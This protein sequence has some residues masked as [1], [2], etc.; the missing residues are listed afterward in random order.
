M[1]VDTLYQKLHRNFDAQ[2]L[3]LLWATYMPS[4]IAAISQSVDEV[5]RVITLVI[6]N[7]NIDRRSLHRIMGDFIFFIEGDI[8]A[9]CQQ[10][11]NIAEY[12]LYEQGDY[13]R[14]ISFYEHVQNVITASGR[15]DAIPEVTHLLNYIGTKFIDVMGCIDV[16]MR[17]VRAGRF[18]PDIATRILEKMQVFLVQSIL[19]PIRRVHDIT[20]END[21]V[22]A[23][24][25]PNDEEIPMLKY[26]DEVLE[27]IWLGQ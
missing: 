6:Q 20:S 7:P 10:L 14:I 9:K 25:W 23:V 5:G 26:S 18:T 22:E 4:V 12:S 19:G 13:M 8:I 16:V 17:G 21:F 24:L 27:K 2:Y 11:F 1:D 15:E 3:E